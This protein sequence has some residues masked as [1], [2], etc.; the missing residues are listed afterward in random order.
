MRAFV[1]MVAVLFATADCLA[2][3]SA[4]PELRLWASTAFGKFDDSHQFAAAFRLDGGR[5]FFVHRF[6]IAAGVLAASD[7]TRPFLSLGPVWRL[8]GSATRWFF[9]LGI[10]PTL[11]AGSVF[12]G[13]DLGGNFH[14]TSTATLGRYLGST[15]RLQLA[16][17]VQHISNGGLRSTNPGMD[18]AGVSILWTPVDN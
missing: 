6:E 10:S 17:R 16:V 14:F 2:A 13:R 1:L 18:L 8:P 15:R 4:T 12:E 7:H 9:E 5:R 11:L 3:D